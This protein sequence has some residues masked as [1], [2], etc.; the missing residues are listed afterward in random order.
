VPKGFEGE[1]Y[2]Y[3]EY[4]DGIRVVRD[5]PDRKGYMI[6]FFGTEGEVCVSRNGQIESTPAELVGRPLSPSD[7]QLYRSTYHQANWIEGIKTRKPTICP[8]HVGHRTGTICQLAGIAERLARPLKWD[9]KAEQIIG[10]AEAAGW[11]DRARRA[12]YELPV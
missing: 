12:G 3:Y 1:E 6:R 8:A 5:H 4:A 11:Q 10:D 2:A 9:P 7:T